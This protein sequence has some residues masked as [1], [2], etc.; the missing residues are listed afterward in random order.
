MVW[1]DHSGVLKSLGLKNPYLT[2]PL[3]PGFGVFYNLGRNIGAMLGGN[4]TPGAAAMSAFGSAID[5]LDPLGGSSSFLNFVAPTIA[6]PW[7]DLATNRDFAGNPIVPDRASPNPAPV[8]NSQRYWSTTGEV[9]KW[10]AS[11]INKLTGGDIGR[12]GALDWSPEQLDYVYSYLTGTLGRSIERAATTG[13]NIVQG[14]YQNIDVNNVPVIRRFVGNTGSRGNAN[15]YYDNANDVFST[16]NTVKAYQQLGDAG[17][18][19][20]ALLEHPA[21]AQMIPVF[22]QAE[23]A[24]QDLRAQLRQVRASTAISEDRRRAMEQQIKDQQDA[25]MARANQLYFTTAHAHA[26]P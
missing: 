11:Q 12:A 18:V 21:A 8:P 26:V 24:L 13:A 25:I 17:G 5:S 10:I 16:Q 1:V 14:D 20:A 6:D 4:K 3:P 22:T 23:K 15:I 7:V 2:I 9:P 19:R